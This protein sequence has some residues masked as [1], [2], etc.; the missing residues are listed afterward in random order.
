MSYLSGSYSEPK[1]FLYLERIRFKR[2]Q[3]QR[4]YLIKPVER[5]NTLFLLGS[6][7]NKYSITISRDGLSCS[8]PDSNPCCKHVIF[9]LWILG[10]ARPN[11]PRVTVYPTLIQ[12]LIWGDHP[13]PKVQAALLDSQTNRLCSVGKNPYYFWCHR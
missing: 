7:G 3:Q 4:F 5:T 1:V 10:F 6:T 8:C 11:Q 2:A 12:E 9:V 13:S